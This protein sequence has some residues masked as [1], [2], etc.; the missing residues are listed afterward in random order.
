MAKKIRWSKTS[1]VQLQVVV[2]YL[3]SD[4]GINTTEKIS[5]YTGEADLPSCPVSNYRKKVHCIPI[6][7]AACNHKT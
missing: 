7:T 6:R 1:K 2:N 5:E 4:W 3:I